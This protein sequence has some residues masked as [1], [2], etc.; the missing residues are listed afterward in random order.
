MHKLIPDRHRELGEY[1]IE[2]LN[3]Y[4]SYGT[5]AYVINN[6]KEKKAILFKDPIKRIF[7][8]NYTSFVKQEKDSLI[9]LSFESV[10]YY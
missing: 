5:H 8:R 4:T 9:S 2:E 6:D 3:I 1:H 10:W 7:I